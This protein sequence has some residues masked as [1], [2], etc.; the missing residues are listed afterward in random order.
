MSKETKRSWRYS[1]LMK[2]GLEPRNPTPLI[3]INV[4]P[5]FPY[6]I[7]SLLPSVGGLGRDHI[8]RVTREV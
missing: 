6:N 8:L 4:H 7:L 2:I 1:D 3:S 5:P